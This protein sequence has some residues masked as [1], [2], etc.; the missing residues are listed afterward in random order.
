MSWCQIETH[1]FL[2]QMRRL[3]NVKKPNHG[4]QATVNSLRSC[5]ALAIGGA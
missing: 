1:S 4:V 2:S 3:R 5:L